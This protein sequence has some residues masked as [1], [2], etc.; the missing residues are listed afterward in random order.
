MCLIELDFAGWNVDDRGWK[1]DGAK[2]EQS[3]DSPYADISSGLV[4][5]RGDNRS[6]SVRRIVDR[7][8]EVSNRGD[9]KDEVKRRLR[10]EVKGR[11]NERGENACEGDVRLD[12]ENEEH[13]G[14]SSP[15]ECALYSVGNGARRCVTWTNGCL[16]MYSGQTRRVASHVQHV[17]D[18]LSRINVLCSRK[19]KGTSYLGRT[20]S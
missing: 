17:K 1:S 15:V 9:V 6:V 20:L 7:R 10:E 16:F 11:A 8:E 3:G 19:S 18:C 5:S 4:T 2:S 12:N 13:V 14:N